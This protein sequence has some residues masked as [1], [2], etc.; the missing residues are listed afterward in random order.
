MKHSSLAS[1]LQSVG[2]SEKESKIFLILLEKGS[3]TATDI[4]REVGMPR[5][6]ALLL[7]DAL[8]EKGFVERVKVGGHFEWEAGALDDIETQVTEK[9]SLF[10]ESVPDLREIVRAQGFGKKFKVS[11]LTGAS[12]FLK[13]YYKLL[14]L[15]SGERVY[16]FE[17]T[18][19][20]REKMKMR[21]QSIIK[22]QNAFRESGIIIEILGSRES[23]T[24]VKRRKATDVLR[25]HENRLIIT[26]ELPT[27]IVD[28][29]TDIAVLPHTVILF[30]PKPEIAVI[31]DSSELAVSLRKIFEGLTMIS[32]TVDANKIV[33]DL[34]TDSKD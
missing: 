26:H 24:E 29:P 6:S 30:I 34:L 27:H 22:W 31:I 18:E 32:T 7:L 28:F 11:I 17:G 9:F 2:L 33:R 8:K 13:G 1:S 4:A 3:L 12:G 15:K 20:V 19:S 16:V 14:E 21:D 23:L 25:A 5:T 10:K